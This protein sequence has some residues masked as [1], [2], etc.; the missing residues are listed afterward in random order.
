M[1]LPVDEYIDKTYDKCTVKCASSAIICLDFIVL[2]SE[3]FFNLFN[4]YMINLKSEPSLCLVRM[5]SFSDTIYCQS[6]VSR[7]IR[8]KNK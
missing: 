7:Y 6:V 5:H 3:D 1:L 8:V 4:R 2:K